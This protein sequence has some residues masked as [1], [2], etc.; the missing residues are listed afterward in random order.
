[1]T[2]SEFTGVLK[3]VHS[4]FV[5]RPKPEITQLYNN[6]GDLAIIPNCIHICD[7]EVLFTKDT[8][9]AYSRLEKFQCLPWQWRSRLSF[10]VPGDGSQPLSDTKFFLSDIT[11]QYN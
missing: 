1:M 4:A 3:K 6:I 10:P 7:F 5:V 2:K 9:N 8:C 11:N